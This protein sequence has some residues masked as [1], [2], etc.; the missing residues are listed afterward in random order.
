MFMF[1]LFYVTQHQMKGLFKTNHRYHVIKSEM[2]GCIITV[3][4][5]TEV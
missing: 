4:A 2:D 1:I 5:S 3:P